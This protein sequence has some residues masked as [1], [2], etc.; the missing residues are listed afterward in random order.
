MV[1][2]VQLESVCSHEQVY[3]FSRWVEAQKE[4]QRV[5]SLENVALWHWALTLQARAWR[6]WTVYISAMRAAHIRRQGAFQRFS[7]RLA[8]HAIS[9]WL[10][11]ALKIKEGAVDIS[12]PGVS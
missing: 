3:Y 7:E 2:C 5:R 9:I 4:A 1:M 6:S 10:T 12:R 8:K 11:A